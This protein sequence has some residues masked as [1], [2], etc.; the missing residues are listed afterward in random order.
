MNPIQTGLGL[1]LSPFSSTVIMF[2]F[3][4][5]LYRTILC[6]FLPLSI[7]CYKERKLTSWRLMYAL[8]VVGCMGSMGFVAFWLYRPFA[9]SVLRAMGCWQYGP[10]C[11]KLYACMDWMV[12]LLFVPS[13]WAVGFIDCVSCMGYFLFQL[14]VWNDV[15][16]LLVFRTLSAIATFMGYALVFLSVYGPDFIRYMFFVGCGFY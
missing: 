3:H 11:W 8:W 13:V 16:A 15:L 9:V 14:Y 4:N 1:K 6:Q 5:T 7:K 10:F 12:C 2:A